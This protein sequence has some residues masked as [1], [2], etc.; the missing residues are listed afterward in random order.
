MKVVDA[1]NPSV[2]YNDVTMNVTVTKPPGFL[3]K[4]LRVIVG[5]IA[6]II[7]VILAL[8]WMRAARRRRVDVR[9]LAAMLRRDGEQ[10]GAE[11]RAPSKWSE[12]FRFIIRDE[13]QQSARLDYPQSGFPVYTARR[14]RTGEVR[15]MTPEGDRYDIVVGGPEEQLEHNGLELGFRDT[16]RGRAAPR[17]GSAGLTHGSGR[18]GSAPPAVSQPVG[19]DSAV[20]A[21]PSPAQAPA[22][23]DEWL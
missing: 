7:L 14:A 4:Y 6:L 12:T 16:R 17:P 5:I 3:A 18:R 8:L 22:Q 2:V 13:E 21:S 10:V 9:G 19:Q 23:E 1:A 11:L 15:L 20:T